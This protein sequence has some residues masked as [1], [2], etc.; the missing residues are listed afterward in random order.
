MGRPSLTGEL[1]A[2]REAYWKARNSRW[3]Q[4]LK[5]RHITAP[6][7]SDYDAFSKIEKP[8]AKQQRETEKA[9][10]TGPRGGQYSVSSSGK[11]VYAHR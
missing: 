5:D 3:E 10:Q 7:T 6:A 2:S 9:L 4:F 11:K 8:Y 1:G